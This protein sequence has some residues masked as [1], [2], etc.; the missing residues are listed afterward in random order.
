MTVI[1]KTSNCVHCDSESVT[2]SAAASRT[3]HLN[4]KAASA[5]GQCNL[6]RESSVVRDSES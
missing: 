2:V 1:K 3:A 6:T 4:F 5:P